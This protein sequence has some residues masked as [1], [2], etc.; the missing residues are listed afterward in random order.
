MAVNAN[1]AR[2]MK[3]VSYKLSMGL[4][5]SKGQGQGQIKRGHQMKMLQVSYDTCRM[6][7]LGRRT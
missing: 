3:K 2:G 5:M 7:L 4:I 6:G 1:F